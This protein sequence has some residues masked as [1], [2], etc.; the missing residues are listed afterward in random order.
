M[1][2]GKR[3]RRESEA[4]G[5]NSRYE[6]Q[7]RRNEGSMIPQPPPHCMMFTGE[8]T[9]PPSDWDSPK[10]AQRAAHRFRDMQCVRKVGKASIAAK[11]NARTKKEAERIRE[12]LL[13]RV[14]A[15]ER[16]ATIRVPTSADYE[17][18]NKE[19]EP[20]SLGIIP[21]SRLHARIRK[22]TLAMD[23]GDVKFVSSLYSLAHPLSS[24]WRVPMSRAIILPAEEGN[25]WRPHGEVKLE[26]HVFIHRL[27]CELISNH[28]LQ[29]IF[30]R[31]ESEAPVRERKPLREYDAS[32]TGPD[33]PTDPFSLEAFMASATS[34]GY[35]RE[36]QPPGL[37]VSLFP[38]QR[39]ALAWMLD[40]EDQN[41]RP[42]GINEIFWC[43]AR[44]PF[45]SLR[46]FLPEQLK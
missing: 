38:F 7:R 6:A 43:V 29:I 8:P 27:A 15:T 25:Q 1:A 34:R 18:W 36:S 14:Q 4:G 12:A 10:A 24:P 21:T 37:R 17:R 31:I 23:E 39:E 28:D 45:H 22:G 30:S 16:S 5:A 20:G 9:T 33:E 41:A 3:K 26:V 19:G 42:K 35:R 32:L 46:A 11:L 2:V 13:S 40:M 44:L